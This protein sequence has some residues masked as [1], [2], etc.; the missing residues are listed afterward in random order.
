VINQ[1]LGTAFKAQAGG[2]G[3]EGS[4][5]TGVRGDGDVGVRGSGMVGVR[6]EGNPGSGVE[7]TSTGGSGVVGSTSAPVSADAAGVYGAAG[8]VAGVKGTSVSGPGGVFSSTHGLGAYVTTVEGYGLNV[9]SGDNIGVFAHSGRWTNPIYWFGHMGML[10]IAEEGV[11]VAGNGMIGGSFTGEQGVRASGTI[12]GV[13]GTA[14]A[15]AGRGVVGIADNYNSI[16]VSGHGMFGT[17]V[18]GFGETGVKGTSTV[19]VGVRGAGPTGVEG[20]SQIG[21]GVYGTS[22]SGDGVQG[23]SDAANKSGVYGYNSGSGIG[24]TG[25]SV[26]GDGVQGFGPTG[27]YGESSADYGQA[28]YGR[29]TGA[30]TEG[31]LGVSD[32]SVGVYGISNGGRTG[33]T[34]GVWGQT[35][36]TWGFYTGQSLY[37]GGNC[38]GCTVAFVGQNGDAGSLEVGDVVSISGIAPPLPGQ[39]TPILVV[40]RA[41]ATRAGALG[42]VQSRAVVTTSEALA[43][44]N[45]SNPKNTIEVPGLAP[46]R[47]APGEYL[48]VVVQG[49]VQVRVD[50]TLGAIQVGDPVGPSAAPG[51]GQSLSSTMPA[52]PV[53]GRALEP[54]TKETG[55]IWVLVLGR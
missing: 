18:S 16:G 52:A 30:H 26:R 14:D 19:G 31:I 29:G 22:A 23:D 8:D 1:G 49:L 46:G 40:Q 38:T 39:Q 12:T 51:L 34:F 28:I 21:V 15:M 24:V 44:G 33:N 45:E 11:G 41:T 43:P 27:V 6:G 13:T 35:N 48:F 47:V 3:I 25:R 17:G 5:M 20:V 4:G 53:L 2:I 9:Q 32:Q 42:V 10:G 37:V 7:G 36:G 54:L 50:A 55:L